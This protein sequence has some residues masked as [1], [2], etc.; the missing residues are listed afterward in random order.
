MAESKRIGDCDILV[1]E[2]LVVRKAILK[3]S[4]NGIQ[5]IIIHSDSQ[6]IENSFK[7]KTHVPKDIVNLLEDVNCSRSLFKKSRIAYCN[8]LVNRKVDSLTIRG[9][10]VSLMYWCLC[11]QYMLSFLFKINCSAFQ[12]IFRN[13]FSTFSILL[14]SIT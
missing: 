5:R 6:L 4:Q 7:W 2:C 10:Y 9:S 8:R 11:F 3:G 13:F 12:P 14:Y 1:T